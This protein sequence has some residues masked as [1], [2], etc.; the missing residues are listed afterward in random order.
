MGK[1]LR[2]VVWLLAFW[3]LAQSLFLWG[4]LALTPVIG[5]QL[6]AQA[7]LQS[8]LV[9]TYLFLGRLALPPLGLDD[10][11]TDRA[12]ERFGPQIADTDS[13]PETVV[14]RFVAAQ[15]AGERLDHVGTPLLLLLSLVL[16]LRRQK[17]IR[18]FGVRN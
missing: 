17:P 9:A 5:Q 18:S 14:T 16:H 6:R 15:S 10:R 11:A 3:M 12:A 13:P 8:P 7:K 2:G 1:W 4:G